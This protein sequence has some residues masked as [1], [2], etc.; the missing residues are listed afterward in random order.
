MGDNMKDD[1]ANQALEGDLDLAKADTDDV[2]GGRQ[3]GTDF[4]KGPRTEKGPHTE[5]GPRP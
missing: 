1:N 5:K 4:K 3:K 2:V